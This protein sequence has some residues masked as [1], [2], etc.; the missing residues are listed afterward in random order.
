MSPAAKKRRRKGWI[1]S[2]PSK[3]FGIG[4]GLR[5]AAE[6]LSPRLKRLRKKLQTVSE[7]ATRAKALNPY[8]GAFTRV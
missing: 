4:L 5:P 6:R 3:D 2:T 7:A 1:N 8:I